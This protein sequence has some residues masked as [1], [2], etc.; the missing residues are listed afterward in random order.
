MFSHG[1]WAGCQAIYQ[2]STCAKKL[3]PEQRYS[4]ND[5]RKDF[6]IK[7]NKRRSE[8]SGNQTQVARILQF[9]TLPIV[10]SLPIGYGWS[11]LSVKL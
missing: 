9:Y 3:I 4:A 6:M 10:V 11:K 1:S 8:P 5:H 7:H 2:Y